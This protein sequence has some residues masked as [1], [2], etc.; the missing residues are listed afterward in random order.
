MRQGVRVAAEVIAIL[1]SVGASAAS[2]AEKFQP[3][4]PYYF[5]SFDPAMKPWDPGQDLNFEEVFKNYA[6]YEIIFDKSGQEITVNHYIQN[7]KERSNRFLIRPD[8][9]LEAK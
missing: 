4:A 5:E 6:Y 2:L 1:F 7:R 8:R 3:D 9:A